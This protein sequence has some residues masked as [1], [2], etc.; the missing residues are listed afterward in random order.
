MR[1]LLKLSI[2]FEQYQNFVE[3]ETPKRP[4][5]K[6]FTGSKM[7]FQ[8]SKTLSNVF[9]LKFAEPCTRILGTYIC[10]VLIRKPTVQK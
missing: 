1:S 5:L 8:F 4:E 6:E 10:S 9:L 7:Y 2:H 3:S